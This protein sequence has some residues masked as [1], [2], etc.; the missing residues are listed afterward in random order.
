MYQTFIPLLGMTFCICLFILVIQFLWQ[1]IEK[2]V[3][4]GIETSILLE[5]FFY[6][7]LN[8]IP[9]ALPLAILLASLMT[10]GNLG[11]KLELLAIKASGVSLLKIMR[12]LIVLV[13][14][15]TLGSFILQDRYAPG[16]RVK[17]NSLLY[18]IQNTTPEVDIPEGSFYDRL[19]GYSIYVKKKDL[20]TRMLHDVMIY[21]LTA[22]NFKNM[23]LDI[24]DSAIIQSSPNRDYMMIT[25]F[26][27]ERYENINSTKST[28]T[29]FPPHLK[30]RYQKK[31]LTIVFNSEFNRTDESRYSDSHISK[32]MGQ[33]V[34]SKDSLALILDSLNIL[35]R[36][37]VLDMPIVKIGE[38]TPSSKQEKQD[39]S[40][41]LVS[42]TTSTN[43][44]NNPINDSLNAINPD[45]TYISVD[46]ILNTFNVREKETIYSMALSEARG[47]VVNNLKYYHIEV[48]KPILQKNIRMHIIFWHK[49]I[50]LSLSCLV[51]F[52]IGASLG[53]IV[54]KGGV[55]VP[56]IISIVLFIFY[57]MIDTIGYKLARDGE[58]YPWAGVWLSTFILV[59]ISIFLTYK[60]TRES[61]LF[62]V[63]AYNTFARKLLKVHS[64][65]SRPILQEANPK[66]IPS[67]EQVGHF[68]QSII[69]RFNEF[70]N[71]TLKDI[72]NNISK[73][74]ID[75]MTYK[76]SQLLALAILKER[77]TYFFDVKVNN[78]DYK[79]SSR[80]VD[81]FN[82]N[83][84]F[85]LIPL[86]ILMLVSFVLYIFTSIQ[87]LKWISVVFIVFYLSFWLK[88][89]FYL[90]DLTKSINL[91]NNIDILE[92]FKKPLRKFLLKNAVGLLLLSPVTTFTIQKK[93]NKLL[94]II[95][96]KYF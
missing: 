78:Y 2:L 77:D 83:N 35:D 14:I 34:A 84:K 74:N 65:P 82:K 33:L 68:P 67:M 26:N 23:S 53:S 45:Y 40:K 86:F 76:Q 44:K 71:K 36:K 61:A 66:F 56:I 93:L 54:K 90:S 87:L 18:S 57:Y 88:S 29:N 9:M 63:E 73:Y 69:D 10:F 89:L 30:E 17:V 96:N 11:E 60:S 12:P 46:S 50:T 13:V 59:P 55:G 6:L 1:H 16:Y 52:F 92:Y 47:S 5:M 70:D 21:D 38:S 20:E 62:N 27:G 24:C 48:P 51:F 15:I 49:V 19:P 43:Q 41:E 31:Q 75:G 58:W 64:D 79:L 91:D 28:T 22:G 3:G 85:V 95:E 25:L 81:Y 39:T 42:N 72:V 32:T 37:L 4:K 80:L 94:S 7:I 8:L